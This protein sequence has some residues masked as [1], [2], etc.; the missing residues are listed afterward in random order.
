[1]SKK[2]VFSTN[3]QQR[4]HEAKIELDREETEKVSTKTVQTT[5]VIEA[6]LLYA[7]KEVILKR[8]KAG[9]KPDTVTGIIKDAL[10]HIVNKEG[11]ST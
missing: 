3:K 8:K 4:L 11:I 5:L 9:I 10:Q 2:P 6:P 1:M 7:V